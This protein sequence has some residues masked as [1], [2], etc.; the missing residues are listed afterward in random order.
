MGISVARMVA[1][2]VSPL[3]QVLEQTPVAPQVKHM[4]RAT[5]ELAVL[6]PDKRERAL[7]L[8]QELTEL[9]AGV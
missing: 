8:I 6:L 7:S 9:F 3:E 4:V 1:P 2:P 5:R